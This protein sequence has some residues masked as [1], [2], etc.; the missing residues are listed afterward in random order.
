MAI[1][2]VPPSFQP[3]EFRGGKWLL[4]NV[5]LFVFQLGL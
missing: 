3:S 5:G 4:L 2:F 1:L